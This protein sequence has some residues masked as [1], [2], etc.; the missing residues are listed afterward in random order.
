MD[1]GLAPAAALALRGAAMALALRGA[2]T[3]LALPVLAAVDLAAASTDPRLP[4]VLICRFEVDSTG[5]KY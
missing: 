5:R 2:A 4:R 1:V 3:A